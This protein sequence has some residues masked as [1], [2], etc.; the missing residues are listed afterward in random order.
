M[1]FYYYNAG[2]NSYYGN[3]INEHRVDYKTIPNF[4][5]Q[6]SALLK[7][8][9]LRSQHEKRIHHIRELELQV[10]QERKLAIRD[11]KLVKNRQKSVQ[12][13]RAELQSALERLK[14]VR[15][16]SVQQ[17]VQDLMRRG[18]QNI[19]LLEKAR[20]IEVRKLARLF[21]LSGDVDDVLSA[22]AEF[23][24]V[25]HIRTRDGE[26]MLQLQKPEFNTL[27]HYLVWFLRVLCD[28]MDVRLLFSV[29]FEQGRPRICVGAE[30]LPLFMSSRHPFGIVKVGM[31]FLG[32]NM[33]YLCWRYGGA[34]APSPML[35]ENLK[36]CLN[37]IASYRAPLLSAQSTVDVNADEWNVNLLKMAAVAIDHFRSVGETAE[38]SVI[39]LLS[40]LFQEDS[41]ALEL[42][43]L[44]NVDEWSL[45]QTHHTLPAPPSQT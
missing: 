39:A 38:P 33:A 6:A 45:I 27:M 1:Y 10:E 37:A 2:L 28:C 11:S 4:V 23:T 26:C 20:I 12:N 14:E 18:E 35:L 9:Q 36:R 34:P 32:V 3:R 7:S 41:D 19:V 22:D 13:R 24:H 43:G 29:K 8:V 25:F 16:G 17:Q 30:S 44:V 31:G 42:L 40:D 15:A 21:R 5:D